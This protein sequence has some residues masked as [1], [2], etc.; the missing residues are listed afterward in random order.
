[1]EEGRAKP[2]QGFPGN[3]L[4]LGRS[5]GQ[6][7]DGLI[8]VHGVR[9]QGDV[10]V[11]QQDVVG[12]LS[13]LA[14]PGEDEFELAPDRRIYA[15]GERIEVSWSQGP[16]NRWDWLGVY[17]ASASDPATRNRIGNVAAMG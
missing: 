11:Q 6:F 14:G 17:E 5:A 16:A 13:T 10:V 9:R 15:E 4:L 3:R 2:L 12:G 7:K 1:V 8:G